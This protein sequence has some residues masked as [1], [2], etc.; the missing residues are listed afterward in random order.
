MASPLRNISLS[1]HARIWQVLRQAGWCV[2]QTGV[3]LT[4][5]VAANTSPYV[6]HDAANHGKGFVFMDVDGNADSSLLTVK[7]AGEPATPAPVVVNSSNYTVDY[8]TGRITFVS[9]PA[10]AITADLCR[11]VPQVRE[12]DPSVEELLEMDLPLIAYELEDGSGEPFAVASCLQTRTLHA[13]LTLYAR[14]NGERQDLT[15][16]LS[17]GLALLQIFDFA[18][19]NHLTAAGAVDESFSRQSQYIRTA[20]QRVKPRYSMIGIRSGG[21]PKEMFMSVVHLSLQTIR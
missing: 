17:D 12:G 7:M 2:T 16:D 19:H 14:N 11:W 13:T 3:S 10:R 18:E 4:P 8:R 5:V 6:Y 1:L 20:S 15:C 21:T 9:K